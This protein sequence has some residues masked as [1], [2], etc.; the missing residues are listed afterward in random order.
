M[1]MSSAATKLQ[2]SEHQGAARLFPGHLFYRVRHC[3]LL[4][5]GARAD[6]SR[7][8]TAFRGGTLRHDDH[9]KSVLGLAAPDL[10]A[11][12]DRSSTGIFESGITSADRHALTQAMIRRTGP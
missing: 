1:L 4:P 10:V 11:D 8:R 5:P 9:M 7:P 6:G 2:V 3:S 12:L